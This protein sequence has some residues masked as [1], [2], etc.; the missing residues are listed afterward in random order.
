M[1]RRLA[2][3]LIADVAGYSRLMGADDEGT[4]TTLSTYRDVVDSLIAE[5]QG[6]VFGS[7]G[8]SVVAEFGSAVQSVRCAVAIQRAINR[9]NADLPDRQRMEFRIGVNLGDIMVENDNL[10][11]DGV[12]VAARIEEVADPADICISSAVYE[13][14]AGKV[15]FPAAALGER[16]FKNIARPV[17]IY[18]IDW[19]LEEMQA[20]EILRGKLPLPDKPSVAVLPFVNMSGD[21]E[22]EYFADGITEDIITA[23][24]RNR[25]FF[26]IARN[27]TFTYKKRAVDVKQVAREL[28][29]RYVLEGSVRKAGNRIRINTQLI[30]ADSGAHLWVERYDR[31]LSDVFALQDEITESV[32][33]AIEPELLIVE[34]R[35]AARK[36]PAHLDAYDLFLRGMWHYYQFNPEDNHR[37]EDC[38]RKAIALDP[39]LAYGYVGLARV[40]HGRTLLDWSTDFDIEQ[41][42]AFEAAQRAIELD[43]KDPYCHYAF[44]LA[45]RSAGLHQQ[46]L[47]E[48]QRAIDLNPNFALAY[49]ALGSVRVYV[50][51]FA[52]AIDP[53]LRVMR[54][55]PNE[56][57][58]FI[59]YYFLGLAHYHL[60]DYVQAVQLAERGLA[61]RRI[62]ALYELLVAS[63]GQLG[64]PDR[65][66]AAREDMER[67]R[68]ANVGRL[69]R[70]KNR[71]LNPTDFEHFREGL[72]KAGIL[73]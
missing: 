55:N 50:G 65:A 9:R 24:S 47:A 29:V 71:Y 30:E 69:W 63:L 13:Q 57:L 11:G 45:N 14:I 42:L 58:A 64:R 39:R 22:Q 44:C 53:L 62:H 70:D 40:L 27:S 18:R 34:G 60:H 25:W 51:H 33:A 32:V 41:R 67:L 17:S 5:H 7:A 4:L 59:F 20:M 68:T 12:N 49:Y 15:S 3:I 23:L 35:R 38:M 54:L 8:D 36:N 56:P 1:E 37:A 61:L 21:S 31:D 48:A 43:G 6:R 66:A 16:N 10:F 26:V 73:E 2:A 46:A 52:E 28:S 19:R 72:K